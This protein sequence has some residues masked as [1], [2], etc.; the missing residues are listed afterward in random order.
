MLWTNAMDDVENGSVT[1][2][3]FNID[4]SNLDVRGI[5]DAD[6]VSVGNVDAD[7][8]DDKLVNE[9]TEG[10]LEI[11]IMLVKLTVLATLIVVLVFGNKPAL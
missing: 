2:D 10:D 4:T 11:V 1:V 9:I 5:L 6:A 7:F 8:D 3:I